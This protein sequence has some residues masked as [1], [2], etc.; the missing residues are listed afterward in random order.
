MSYLQNWNRYEIENRPLDTL[1]QLF[2][3]YD[4]NKFKLTVVANQDGI[5]LKLCDS[6]DIHELMPWNDCGV[7]IVELLLSIELI[8]MKP[9]GGGIEVNHVQFERTPVKTPTDI[10]TNYRVLEIRGYNHLKNSGWVGNGT[11]KMFEEHEFVERI[12]PLH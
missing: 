10:D 9:I 8:W 11:L 7:P 3:F 1:D 4:K 12:V 6:S 5:S 2:I